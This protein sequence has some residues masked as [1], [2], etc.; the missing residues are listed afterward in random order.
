MHARSHLTMSLCV[1]CSGS[2]PNYI[3]CISG[4]TL[5]VY[6]LRSKVLCA[7]SAPATTPPLSQ[8]LVVPS[9]LAPTHLP[10]ALRKGT[11]TLTSLQFVITSL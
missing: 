3:F 5:Q 2:L 6:V 9:P 8:D 11:H 1:S 4:D 7:P 10:I